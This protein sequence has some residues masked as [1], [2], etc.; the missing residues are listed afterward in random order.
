MISE[1]TCV[2]KLHPL[3]LKR[4]DPSEG[5]SLLLKYSRTF[6]IFTSTATMDVGTR[7]VRFRKRMRI[8]VVEAMVDLWEG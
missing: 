2:S 7:R 3:S 1:D 6:H 8:M 5:V 4:G